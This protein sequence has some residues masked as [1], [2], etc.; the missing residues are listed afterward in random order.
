MFFA[1]SQTSF[2]LLIGLF[3]FQEVVRYCVFPLQGL[4]GDGLRDV[5]ALVLIHFECELDGS[6]LGLRHSA[7]GEFKDEFRLC[8]EPC[9]IFGIG[10]TM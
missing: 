5:D 6:V 1:C 3:T 4:P 8:S 7:V 10:Q 9:P 2:L